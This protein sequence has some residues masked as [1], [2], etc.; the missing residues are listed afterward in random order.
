MVEPTQDKSKRSPWRIAVQEAYKLT[1]T[2]G[3]KQKEFL[4]VE[5][6]RNKKGGGNEKICDMMEFL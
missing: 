2:T 6:S 3:I 4:T 1:N 5:V